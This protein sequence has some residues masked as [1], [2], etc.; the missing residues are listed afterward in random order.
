MTVRQGIRET[1]KKWKIRRQQW[2]KTFQHFLNSHPR[3]LRPFANQAAERFRSE[4]FAVPAV[5]P[6]IALGD[7]MFK[8]RSPEHY[9]D[10]GYRALKAI[11]LALADAGKQEVHAILDLP[12]G[13]GRVLR[14]LRA[15]WPQAEI[16][17]CDIEREGADYCARKFGAEAVYS[18]EDP[19]DLVFKQKFDLIWVGS[20][21]T[22]LEAPRWPG[23]LNLFSRSLAPGGVVV[24]TTHGEPIAK[25]M[26]EGEALFG[27][28][29]EAL[30]E[31][32][33]EYEQGGFSYRDY[34]PGAGYGVSL[35]KRAWVE[36][37]VAQTAGLRLLQMREPGWCAQDTV[38]C[39]KEA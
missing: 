18:Q 26:R 3:R 27:L 14:T 35:S 34:R 1:R 11:R 10:V 24:F 2:K 4:G 22:H 15:E 23:F 31:M 17:A 20:L 19:A 9:F 6:D 28:T 37:Q 16:V 32:L 5:L 8:K 33:A 39:V 36:E 21:L 7:R 25:M 12:C 38:I 13:H 29:P 30:Q